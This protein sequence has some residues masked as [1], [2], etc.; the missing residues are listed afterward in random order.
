MKQ[1][2]RL[3]AVAA[4]AA[5]GS[6]CHSSEHVTIRVHHFLGPQSPQQRLLLT[7][8]CDTI[9]K[10]SENQIQCQ[11]Y[12]AMQ[13]G[14]T[15]PQLYDQAKDGVADVIFTL[16]GYSA[17]RFPKMEAFELPFTM[18]DPGAT[19]RAAWDYY[20]KYAKDEFSDTHLLALFVHGPGNIYTVDKP[21]EKMEDLQGLKLRAPTR[22]AGKLLGLLGATPVGMPVPAVPEALSKGVIDGAVMPYEV[23][24]SI[25][26][27]E[28]V[29]YTAE[30]DR[31]FPALYTSVFMVTM[32]KAKYDALPANLKK[33]ID[34][35]SGREM[36]GKFGKTLSGFDVD[37]K[38]LMVQSGV[39]INIIPTEELE[40]WRDVSR[41]LDDEWV[42]DMTAKGQNG[43]MLLK[44]A[45][46]LIQQESG[47]Q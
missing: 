6:G 17:N 4:I 22:M 20:E 9:A 15:P 18:T 45:R 3:F 11:I 23:A 42:K 24:P 27:N 1:W 5:L 13:L 2:A 35:N 39:N 16:A 28:L 34:Q 25:K 46:E 29:K 8:W 43:A 41:Q 36:S 19:S 40:R 47:S 38:K 31:S 30:T 33:V 14:G 10:E 26:M 37:G 21:V 44:S 32:N 12:P 7:P